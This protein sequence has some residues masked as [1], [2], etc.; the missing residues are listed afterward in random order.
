MSPRCVSPISHTHTAV[1][2][3]AGSVGRHVCIYSPTSSQK[4][5]EERQ[6]KHE[7]LHRQREREDAQLGS[8]NQ[9]IRRQF[10]RAEHVFGDPHMNSSSK[11]K[12]AN[13][14]QPVIKTDCSF[15]SRIFLAQAAAPWF[16]VPW[17][18]CNSAWR[19]RALTRLI[20]KCQAGALQGGGARGSTEL[21]AQNRTPTVPNKSPLT[22]WKQLP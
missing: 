10:L 19:P 8:R 17:R 13:P 15:C 7:Q 1:Q 9:V 16:P 18:T 20:C 11:N 6:G 22:G 2:I 12:A 5:R 3:T 21:T 14:T 4:H